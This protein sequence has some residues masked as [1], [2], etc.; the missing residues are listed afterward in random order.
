MAGTATKPVHKWV[1]RWIFSLSTL[2]QAN[3]PRGLDRAGTGIHMMKSLEAPS[4]PSRA[5]NLLDLKDICS[6]H[7][8]QCEHNKAHPIASIPVILLSS[9][10]ASLI[11][12]MWC[13]STA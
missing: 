6:Q 5:H 7:Y 1:S 3:S 9:R 11:G 2:P 10:A 13:L 8:S 12:A 4:S